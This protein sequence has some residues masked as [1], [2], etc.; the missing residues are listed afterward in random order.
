MPKVK[1]VNHA[2][3]FEQHTGHPLIPKK[4]TGYIHLPKKAK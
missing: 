2:A 4:E 1:L 3:I